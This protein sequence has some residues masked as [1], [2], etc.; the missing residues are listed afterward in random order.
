MF[1]I[2]VKRTIVKAVLWEQEIDQTYLVYLK[3]NYMNRN[4]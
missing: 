1:L 2:V 3:S 4:L